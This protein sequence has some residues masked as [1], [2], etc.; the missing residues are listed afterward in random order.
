MLFYEVEFY[1]NIVRLCKSKIN[2]FYLVL[3]RSEQLEGKNSAVL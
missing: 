3:E 1:K 2:I